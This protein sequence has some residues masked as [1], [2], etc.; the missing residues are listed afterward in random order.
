MNRKAFRALSVVTV[1]GLATTGGWSV[2]ASGVGAPTGNAHATF[3]GISLT[4]ISAT[5][6]D[7]VWTVGALASKQVGIIEHWDGVTWSRTR[8][9]CHCLLHGVSARAADDVWV[10][11]SGRQAVIEHYDGSGWTRVETPALTKPKLFAVSADAADDA[12]AVGSSQGSTST[13]TLVLHWDGSSWSVVSSPSF[14]SPSSYLGVSAIA[15]DDVLAV[16][17]VVGGRPL[18]SHWDGNRWKRSKGF[19]TKMLNANA[20]SAVSSEDGWAVGFGIDELGRWDGQTYTPVKAPSPGYAGSLTGVADR[21]SDDAWAVGWAEVRSGDPATTL[22]DH[23]DGTSWHH[24]AS[25]DPYSDDGLMGVS[26]TAADDA[27]AVGSTGVDSFVLH[28]DGTAWSD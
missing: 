26:A 25:P 8:L 22:I 18:L 5:S 3:A 13:Q 14:R 24:V 28:W 2:A 11:G 27:W 20:V 23:W 9:A 7:D 12:W 6:T 19:G 4:A 15:P 17:Y 10:V 1:L 16:G 21:A